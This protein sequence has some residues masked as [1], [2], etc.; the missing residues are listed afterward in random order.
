MTWGTLGSALV[1]ALI[2]WG[3]GADLEPA[4]NSLVLVSAISGLFVERWAARIQKRRDVLHAVAHE[5]FVNDKI[6]GDPIYDKNA[7]VEES[8]PASAWEPPRPPPTLLALPHMLLGVVEH[9]LASGIFSEGRDAELFRRLHLWR[10]RA[11]H[12]NRRL[13]ITEDRMYADLSRPNL[14]KLI[15]E[16][17]YSRVL[18]RARRELRGVRDLLSK[19]YAAEAR[20]V[21]VHDFLDPEGGSR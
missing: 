8:P 3:T 10:V 9:A 11:D 2:W 7:P 1:C 17:R 18:R 21:D 4:V 5:L 19:E 12:L 13:T 16:V 6:L 20:G 14:W 15:E